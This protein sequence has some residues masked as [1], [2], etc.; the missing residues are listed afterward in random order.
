LNPQDEPPSEG[1]PLSGIQNRAL[2]AGPSRKPLRKPKPRSKRKK[3]NSESPTFENLQFWSW[4]LKR[5]TAGLVANYTTSTCYL[6]SP[7]T[8][9]KALAQHISPM[10]AEYG[11]QHC[12]RSGYFSKK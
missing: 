9:T 10:L 1:D 5:R 3:A 11:Q 4:K 6:P 7:M 2:S 8:L 12:Y